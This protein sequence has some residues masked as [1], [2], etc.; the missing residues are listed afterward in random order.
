MGFGVGI[1][2]RLRPVG[3]DLAQQADF[4][5][6]VQ[7]VVD[8]GERHRHL[9]AVCLFVEHLGGEVAVALAEQQPAERHAL[10]RRPQADLAQHGLHV[11]PRAAGQ[12]RT[13]VCR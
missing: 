13:V 8:G 11:M 7:R 12:F 9:G 5:E 6:L 1:E 10:T 2:V 3:R 4:G